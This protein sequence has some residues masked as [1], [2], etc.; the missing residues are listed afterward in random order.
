MQLP[1]RW[2]S[3]ESLLRDFNDKGVEYL[4]FGSMAKSYFHPLSRRG[5]YGPSDQS[6]ERE[7]QEAEVPP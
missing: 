5:R 7:R 3:C 4:I 6:H 1:E 2:W